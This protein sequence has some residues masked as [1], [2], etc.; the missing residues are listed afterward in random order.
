MTTIMA[1]FENML[2]EKRRTQAIKCAEDERKQRGE[3]RRSWLGTLNLN[4][5][6]KPA[7]LQPHDR[8][9]RPN[10][11]RTRSSSVIAEPRPSFLRSR[12][13]SVAAGADTISGT[14]PADPLAF[15]SAP[16]FNKNHLCAKHSRPSRTLGR[17]SFSCRPTRTR[18]PPMS[19]CA[20]AD[21]QKVP[22]HRSSSFAGRDARGRCS[23]RGGS[24]TQEPPLL[25]LS[26]QALRTTYRHQGRVPWYP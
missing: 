16:K 13:G 14:I 5:E 11:V 8:L 23:P 18:G 20:R 22:R 2:N 3:R 9:L 1:T 17:A 12:S 25:R 6:H 21:E 10:A 4:A 26:T 15:E 24:R 7:D 19:T